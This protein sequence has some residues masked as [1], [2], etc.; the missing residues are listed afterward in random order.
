MALDGFEG[1]I[2]RVG[3]E[4]FWVVELVTVY[5]RWILL[6][7]IVINGLIDFDSFAKAEHGQVNFRFI[8]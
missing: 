8:M 1:N 4:I 7:V 2:F 6:I 5:M 3:D